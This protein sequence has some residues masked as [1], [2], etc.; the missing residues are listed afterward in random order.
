MRIGPGGRV[1]ARAS[2]HEG[3]EGHKD[4]LDWNQHAPSFFPG[5]NRA[6]W[7]PA[8]GWTRVSRGSHAGHIVDGPGGERRTAAR[9]LHLVPIE[10][11]SVA[12]RARLFAIAAPWRKSVYADPERTDT[13]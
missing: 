1:L 7:T 13:E 5:A 12:A 8:T 6:A 10:R 3:Y 2:S 4:F 9:R 11:L